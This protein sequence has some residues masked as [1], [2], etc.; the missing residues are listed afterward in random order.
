M[1]LQYPCFEVRLRQS[2]LGIPMMQLFTQRICNGDDD[3][4]HEKSLGFS[5][6]QMLSDGTYS[7][8]NLRPHRSVKI[9][10]CF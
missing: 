8:D 4:R 7:A 3:A 2:D 5:V 9:L 10:D 6:V 1:Y